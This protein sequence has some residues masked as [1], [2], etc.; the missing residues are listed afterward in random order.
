MNYW[1]LDQAVK[2]VEYVDEDPSKG[3]LITIVNKKKMAMPVD[4]QIKQENGETEMKHL[5]VE[6][7]Q[8]GSEWTFKYP[9]DSQI[10][11]VEIEHWHNLT[12]IN[13]DS[14]K[15]GNLLP[16]SGETVQLVIS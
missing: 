12:D 7:W 9:S 16:A 2:S 6:V 10:L 4:I 14:N 8:N 1:K 5:P 15:L 13:E 11:S 3:A